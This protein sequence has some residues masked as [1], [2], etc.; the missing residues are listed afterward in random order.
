M[1]LGVVLVMLASA[2]VLVLPGPPLLW[3]ALQA[4]LAGGCTSIAMVA[5]SDLA[6]RLVSPQS[7]G[8]VMGAQRV[9]VLGIMPVAAVVMGLLGAAV[10]IPVASWIWLALALGSAIPCVALQDPTS[11]L[12]GQVEERH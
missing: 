4:M 3:L 12:P 8:T 2:I 9:L 7:L 6:P 11:S 1:S 5:G 10:G